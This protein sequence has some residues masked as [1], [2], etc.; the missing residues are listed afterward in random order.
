MGAG[1][2][3]N[4]RGGRS[5]LNEI[6]VTPM[7]DVMLVLLIIFMVAAGV[8]TVEL[9]TDSE[10]T[11][12]EAEDLYEQAQDVLR[13]AEQK[14]QK[15][16]KVEV[17]LP[18]VNSEPVVLHEVKKLK[19]EVTDRLQFKIEGRTIVDCLQVSPDMA[20][21]LPPLAAKPD[22]EAQQAAFLPCLKALGEKLVDNKKLQ[23]DKELYVLADR[24]L[25]Y[26]VVLRVMAAVRQAGVTKFGLVAE[27]SIL[28][29]AEVEKTPPPVP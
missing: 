17:D 1:P 2:G 9:K 15:H 24:A 19:L 7:V 13:E 12:Q 28:E 3:K 8:Q 27:P 4:P 16:E 22:K 18:A 26:G 29:G 11:I 14:Q 6:N 10:R 25:D 23:E 5:V 20:N 21:F